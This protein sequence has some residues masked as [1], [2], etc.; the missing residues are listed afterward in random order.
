MRI[1][2]V[3]SGSVGCLYG[4]RLARAGH[5]V[6]FLMRRDLEAVRRNGL[7]VRSCDGDFH[8]A[9]KAYGRP[10]E[11]GPADLVICALKTT[12]L[13]AA[14]ALI[15]PCMGPKTDVLALMNGLGVEDQFAEWF[16]R[17]HIFGGLAFVCINRGE[18]GVIHHYGYG[19]VVIGHLEDDVARARAI[20]DLFAAA[21]FDASVTP[22]LLR[23][24]WEKLVWN[25]PFSTLA[26]SAGAVT[27]RHI[28]EDDG[29][30]ELA[31]SL[32][33]ET[34]AAGNAELA[35]DNRI[36]PEPLIERMFAN[37]AT[38][39]D[40]RPSML[41]DYLD[42]RPLEVESILGEP[43]RRAVA[44]GVAVPAMKMQYRLVSFLDRL[45]RGLVRPS[46]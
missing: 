37:T 39:G 13:D 2:V 29:L 31:G 41:V 15:R 9:A 42:K 35:E 32:M 46:E 10:E 33:A 20:A 24:R 3:G 17:G 27:T 45:N 1:A 7:T 12:A 19:R 16:P 25:I 11:I 28:M 22:S 4:A 23:A 30:R 36:A 34:I 18:P 6:H 38:M 8:L 5:D 40:Y 21:G 44:H 43:V 26:V 14:R